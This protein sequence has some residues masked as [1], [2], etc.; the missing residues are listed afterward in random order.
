MLLGHYAKHD[1]YKKYY[2]V[3]QERQLVEDDPLH[4]VQDASQFVQIP[5]KMNVFPGHVFTHYPEYKYS[6]EGHVRQSEVEAP[7]HVKHD[8]AQ[9][10]HTGSL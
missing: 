7:L 3:G 10:E 6:P 8:D 1:P 2:P 5:I 9:G 4:V